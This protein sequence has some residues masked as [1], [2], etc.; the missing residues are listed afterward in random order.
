MAED[1]SHRVGIHGEVSTSQFNN[2]ML[3]DSGNGLGE[4]GPL[5]STTAT[6]RHFQPPSSVPHRQSLLLASNRRATMLFRTMDHSQ[7]PV[8]DQKNSAEVNARLR[9]DY[10]TVQSLNRSIESIIQDFQEATGKIQTFAD[11]VDQTNQLLDVWMHILSQTE[12]TKRLLED[13]QW[14]GR[15]TTDSGS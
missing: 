2:R 14:H 1:S 13:P 9:R 11:T 3:I 6:P 8:E 4:D 10:E 15:D 5:I 12:H 7:P